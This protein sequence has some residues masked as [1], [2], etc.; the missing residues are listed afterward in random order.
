MLGFRSAAF[1]TI[2]LAL[3]A[4]TTTIRSNPANVDPPTVPF[5]HHR[6]DRVLHDFVDSRGRVDYA[7]LVAR[8]T[9]LDAY[10]HQ[11]SLISPDSHSKLFATRDERLAF[12]INAYNASVMKAVA[13]AYPISSVGDVGL[14]FWKI[15]F[16]VMQR[17]VIGSTEMNLYDLENLI[18]RERFRDPRVHFA[19]NC[20]SAG[21][22]RLPRQAFRAST[23]SQRLDEETRRFV[24][25]GRNVRVDHPARTVHLSSIFGWYEEDFTEWPADELPADPSL[26]DYVTL[27]ADAGLAQDLEQAK[28]QKYR[29]KLIPY[30]WSLNDQ[31][32]S[33]DTTRR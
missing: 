32:R 23:L 7:G 28:T 8:P 22:P 26:L 27:Y 3:S 16:F 24:H 14:S 4:C 33:D 2:L 31:A 29:I 30:D 9:D 18:I 1:L 12:W 6:F 5:S 19:L 20:A 10:F 13:D 15:G 11:I 25:E 17:V 21:C